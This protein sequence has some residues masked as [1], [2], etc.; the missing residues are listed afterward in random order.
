MSTQALSQTQKDQLRQMLGE[1][2]LKNVHLEI[3]DILKEG[4]KETKEIPSKK[5]TEKKKKKM[6]KKAKK[7]PPQ[8]CE[9]ELCHACSE[10]LRK[11][12]ALS[13]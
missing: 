10:K 2:G 8:V 1:C 9:V 12:G 4:L 5:L 11:A 6:A 7:R 3:G 13:T